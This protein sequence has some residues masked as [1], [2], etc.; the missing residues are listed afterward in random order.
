MSRVNR[1]GR[2]PGAHAR[3][4]RLY[5]FMMKT[6]AWHNLSANAR[7]IYVEIGSRYGGAGSNNGRIPFSV[8][9]AVKICQ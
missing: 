2:N 3:H 4:V 5:H 8:R 7:A 9:E 1:T 6:A